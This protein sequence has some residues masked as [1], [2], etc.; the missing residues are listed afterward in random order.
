MTSGSLVLGLTNG[1]L[2]G[3]LAVGLCLVYKSNRFLNLAHAQL[4]VLSVQLLGKLVLDWG[5]NWWAAFVVCVPVGMAIGAAV[6]RLFIRPLRERSASTVTLLLMSLG[7]GQILLVFTYINSF[8][9]STRALLTATYPEP[10]RSSW[11]VGGAVL[12]GDDILILVLV[13][14]LIAGL[15]LFLRYSVLG[16]S[17]RAAASNPDEAYLC[18]VSP[19]RVSMVTWALAGGISA[20][21]GIF[22]APTQSVYDA[23]ALAP[24]LLLLSLG[25]AALGAFVS[26]PLALLGGVVIGVGD[27]MVQAQTSNAGD[28]ELAVL[29][30]IVA[31]VLIRGRAIG[32]A[33]AAGGAIT[34]DRPPLRIPDAVR[35]HVLVRWR[36]SGPAAIAVVVAILVPLVPVLRSEAS[37]FDL[38]VIVVYA[39]VGVSLT[40]AIGWAGQ[41]SL[42]QFALVGVG[43]F[44]AGRLASHGFS[45]PLTVIVAGA[46]AAAFM[47]AFA[48]PALRVPGLTLA[49]TTLGLAVVGADW[50][51]Q[52]GWF[53]AAGST[54]INLTA[55]NL[56]AGLGHPSGRLA[57]YYFG[58]AV[59]VA[60]AFAMRSLRA[61]NP[62]RLIIATR[63]NEAAAAAFGVTPTT[64]KLAALAI[65]GF[66]AGAAGVV[67]ADAWRNLT[68]DQFGPNISLYLV[69]IPVIGGVGSIGGAIAVAVALEG[70]SIFLTPHLGAI[71]P[72]G[73]AGV[74]AVLLFG[75][76]SQVLVQLRYPQGLAGAVADWY[77]RLVDRLAVTAHQAQPAID[78]PALRVED[79]RLNF[80]GLR[81]LDGAAIEV[82]PGEIVGLIGPNGAGKTTLLNVV[83]GRLAADGG[84][85]HLG[86][87]DV[88]GLDPEMRA[89]L[90]LSRSFQ[91]ATLFPGLSVLETVQ[92]ALANRFKVGVVSSM[93]AVPWAR[94]S[95]TGSHHS[96]EAVV[97]RLGLSAWKDTLTSSLSTGTRRICDLAAQVAAGPRLLLLDEP[98]A[99]V[100]QREAE[101]FGPL[102]RRIRDE[103]DCAMLIVEHDMPLLMG[104]CDRIY[105][106]ELGRVIAEGTPAEIRQN[107]AVI[108][109]YLGTDEVAITRSGRAQP[110]RR[111][112]RRPATNGSGATKVNGRASVDQPVPMKAAAKPKAGAK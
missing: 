94:A 96:A 82:G 110:A 66:L 89:G 29:I 97:E 73:N 104:L 67:W 112:P 111:T 84:R 77:Q 33:F 107:P 12:S 49:V 17:I 90:G 83:S 63:D 19:R 52:R 71:F 18:G 69:A 25:A 16:K 93:L 74:A 87:V 80:G 98:T 50:L 91:D 35:E 54:S 85:I 34:R 37:R 6:D 27:Q 86:G 20:L 40:V 9:P 14:V 64:V 102:L 103:L 46:A 32:Q 10:F 79:V 28:G 105:A 51:F 75:G 45:L 13:P 36:R 88:T 41:V 8:G 68:A 78:L 39:L 100:A 1:I 38:S 23:A 95:E 30:L 15:G 47:V 31:I 21:A 55:P 57:V 22:Q 5:W 92:V 72:G 42:G 59:L 43:A 109:S 61:S 62:G 7:V 26:L 101:A 56:V 76:G 58:L 48:L 44:V 106:M 11:T 70:M 65:S 99:G 24:Y 4:G 53:G 3:L 81:V 2:I 60:G 108:A